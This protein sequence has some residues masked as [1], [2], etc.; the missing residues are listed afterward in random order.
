M[1]TVLLFKVVNKTEGGA[2][3]S[4]H[5]AVITDCATLHSHAQQPSAVALTD[6]HFKVLLP[7]VVAVCVATLH[8]GSSGNGNITETASTL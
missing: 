3:A 5:L 1:E 2:S 6:L 7:A 8:C 4:S